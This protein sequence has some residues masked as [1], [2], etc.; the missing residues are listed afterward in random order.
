MGGIFTGINHVVNGLHDAKTERTTKKIQKTQLNTLLEAAKQQNEA[1][2]SL[3]GKPSKSSILPPRQTFTPPLN[4]TGGR[5]PLTS[6]HM[7]LKVADAGLQLS[8]H[9][10]KQT[11]QTMNNSMGQLGD[12]MKMQMQHQTDMALA[13]LV[14]TLN[15]AMAKE[16]KKTGD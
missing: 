12:V 10:V 5:N 13:K 11:D 8:E 3:S 2:K 1:I 15:E 14:T 16:I 7:P 6:G 9:G 4:M